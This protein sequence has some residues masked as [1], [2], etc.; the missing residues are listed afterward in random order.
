MG[1]TTNIDNVKDKTQE[2]IEF[3]KPLQ[4]PTKI[5]GKAV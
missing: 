4:M 1:T 2:K 3:L 5:T